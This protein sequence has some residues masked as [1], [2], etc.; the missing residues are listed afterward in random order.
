VNAVSAP[1]GYQFASD[2]V[3]TPVD[4]GGWSNLRTA[5]F[6]VRAVYARH[7]P[8]LPTLTYPDFLR[9]RNLDDVDNIL[10][11]E[12]MPRKSLLRIWYVVTQ[13][14]ERLVSGFYASDQELQADREIHVFWH[15]LVSPKSGNLHT[16]PPQLGSRTQLAQSF[17]APAVFSIFLHALTRNERTTRKLFQNRLSAPSCLRNL[18][19]IGST[20]PGLVNVSQL[21]AMLPTSQDLLVD[22]ATTSLA[23]TH[24]VQSLWQRHAD[25]SKPKFA[26]QP[27]EQAWRAYLGDLMNAMLTDPGLARFVIPLESSP[28]V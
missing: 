27:T 28:E 16:L 5:S 11:H 10:P 13:F 18:P 9:E 8:I 4:T 19:S 20:P 3:W 7:F 15:E 23:L 14:A 22:L 17:L 26:Q 6:S 1:V 21:E 2:S 25:A 24:P 12:V